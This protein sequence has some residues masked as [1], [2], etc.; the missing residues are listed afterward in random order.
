MTVQSLELATP[1]LSREA[2]SIDLVTN[3]TIQPLLP[4]ATTW[5]WCHNL[6]STMSNRHL[7]ALL[8]AS[9]DSHTMWPLDRSEAATVVLHH[10][11]NWRQTC[12][13][14]RQRL[15]SSQERAHKTP[16]KCRPA[17]RE[18]LRPFT[19]IQ[20]QTTITRSRG[21]MLCKNR[22][23]KSCS[24]SNLLMPLP[25]CQPRARNYVSN[26]SNNKRVIRS[27]APGNSLWTHLPL[28]VYLM[29]THWQFNLS[30]VPCTLNLLRSCTHSILKTYRWDTLE[31]H[32]EILS[33]HLCLLCAHACRT[34]VRP[35]ELQAHLEVSHLML[36][37]WFHQPKEGQTM[38][39]KILLEEPMPIKVRE[40]PL[41]VTITR[42]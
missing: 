34:W 28:E 12:N 27:Q 24:S 5:A 2:P 42:L 9:A 31:T 14:R 4:T 3:E 33:Y 1:T 39:S 17:T 11:S 22:Q 32:T 15:S 26:K 21:R 41:E 37:L 10:S 13:K 18:S 30:K 6:T 16:T 36:A 20:S 40:R 29:V 25:P 38:L 7:I 8:R 35:T 19:S 23:Q